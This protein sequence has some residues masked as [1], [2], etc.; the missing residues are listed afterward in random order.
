MTRAF[1]GVVVVR[2]G[3]G[4]SSSPV[5]PSSNASRSRDSNRPL[6]FDPAPRPRTLLEGED[7]AES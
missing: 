2:S 3:G 7:M 1:S 6:A 4:V 5:Q